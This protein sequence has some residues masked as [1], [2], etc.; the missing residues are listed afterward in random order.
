[1]SAPKLLAMLM[2]QGIEG[3]DALLRLA[4][5][6]L[7]ESGLGAELY[8][9]SPDQLQQHLEFRPA[10]RSCTVHLPRSLNLLQP[11]ARERVME[12]VTRAGGQ[13]E[14]MIVHDHRQF[15]DQPTE[16]V[17]SFRDMDRRLAEIPGAPLLFV[18][19]AAGLPPDVFASLFE[20]SSDL[21]R[22]CACV[23]ISHVGIEVCRTA[24]GS[25]FPGVDIC[26]LKAAADLPQ[27]MEAIQR[28]VA[29]ALPA[30]VRLVKRLTALRKPLHFHVHDGHPLSTLSRYGVSDHLGFLQE[31]RLPFAYRGRRLVG[32]M[33]G[34]SG[35][36]AIVRAA[37]E[38][39]AG[40]QLSFMIEV[41][42]QEGRTPLAVHAPLFAHWKDPTNAERMNY[43]LDMLL[44][45]AILVREAFT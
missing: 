13:V 12:F 36:R 42:P 33:F 14:G 45:N 39:L 20:Q 1:M 9:G 37:V 35:L 10:G 44:Q 40:Q 3:D 31:I 41:H 6:R 4:Q 26:G 32:G 28:A 38:G 30:V 29:E 11:E 5:A 17:A 34:P 43:W 19:Y 25:I 15:A 18:E 7:R 21:T 24:Y 22:V 2:K 23:D 16:T 27:R 8:P